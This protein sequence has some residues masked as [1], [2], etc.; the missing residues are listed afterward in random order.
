MKMTS[1]SAAVAVGRAAVVV[2]TVGVTALLASALFVT[3]A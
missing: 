1:S 3:T 2:E